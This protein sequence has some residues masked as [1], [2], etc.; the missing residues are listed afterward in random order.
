MLEVVVPRRRASH[1]RVVVL[2]P[3]VHT[4]L[5]RSL[6]SGSADGA[7]ALEGR[8][9]VVADGLVWMSRPKVARVDVIYSGSTMIFWTRKPSAPTRPWGCAR[10]MDVY[11]SGRVALSTL[12]AGVADDKVI[13][14]YVPRIVK[15]T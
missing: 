7:S 8:D 15:Y 9:L 1:P 4:R 11:R 10:L 14:A 12:L 5:L 13:Y 6:V 3:G 2:T